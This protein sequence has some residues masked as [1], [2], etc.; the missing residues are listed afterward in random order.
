VTARPFTG[1]SDADGAVAVTAM[2]DDVTGLVDSLS[3][4]NTTAQAAAVLVVHNGV[5]VATEALPA[6]T[7]PTT[8]DVS[9]AAVH[10]APTTS[11]WS[12]TPST[13]WNMPSGWSLVGRYPAA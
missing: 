5:T 1:F 11:W 6:H 3:W 2:F 12:G 9:A 4:Q 7:A 13:A 8:R 10:L